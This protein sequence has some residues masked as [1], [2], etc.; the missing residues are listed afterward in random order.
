[1]PRKY[2]RA[3]PAPDNDKPA[4]V[5]PS[6]MKELEELRARN[7]ELEAA[8]EAPHILE[9]EKPKHSGSVSVACKIPQ[10]LILQLQH[11]MKRRIPTGRGSDNDY[12][13]VD[14]MVYGGPRYFVF[15]PSVPALV[16]KNYL[17]PKMIEGG[18]AITDGIPA[19]F[20]RTWLSQ[21]EMAPYVTNRMVFAYDAASTKSA[22]REF[23]KQLSGLEQLNLD[24]KGELND[25]RSPK[26]LNASVS[27]VTGDLDRMND[28]NRV[29][30]TAE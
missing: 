3:A 26:S 25:R 14:V 21:H 9:I 29:G 30:A 16:P 17:M 12:D 1:M 6:I 18:Y 10:G 4:Q 22:A 5:P 19:E 23:E 7:A 11:P 15:G 8:I 2:T 24:E 27:R 20:W 13:V 28:P